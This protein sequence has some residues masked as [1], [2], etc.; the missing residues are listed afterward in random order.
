MGDLLQ[1]MGL[2]SGYNNPYPS[3]QMVHRDNLDL[4]H[5]VPND[6][7]REF[8]YKVLD[9]IKNMEP[10]N[11]SIELFLTTANP[12]VI[13]I[14]ASGFVRRISSTNIDTIK[15]LRHPKRKFKAIIAV[16]IEPARRGTPTKLVVEI[17][18]SAGLRRHGERR[19]R[20]DSSPKRHRSSSSSSSSSI[21]SSSIDSSESYDRH[22]KRSQKPKK[23]S[24]VD[25][26]AQALFG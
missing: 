11:Q 19:R 2:P 7:D 6:D 18:R 20:R 16:E 5:R 14:A 15:K 25:A 22:K 17:R 13:T 10:A 1:E 21:D 3:T 23:G 9:Y 12:S 8:T 24:I 26:A 4:V